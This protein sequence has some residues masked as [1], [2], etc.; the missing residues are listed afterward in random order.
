LA[1]ASA[2]AV[3][4]PATVAQ[5]KAADLGVMSVFL[6]DTVK[7]NDGLQGQIQGAGTPNKAGIGSFLRLR[8]GTQSVTV[9]DVLSNVNFADCL[10]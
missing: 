7:L 6:R 9:L 1:L 4:A 10:G 2:P 5:G 3:A 8:V